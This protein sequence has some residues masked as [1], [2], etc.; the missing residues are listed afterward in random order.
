MNTMNI[1]KQKLYN[2]G[3]KKKGGFSLIESLVL[4]FI[5]SIFVLTAYQVF[6]LAAKYS[7]D[8]KSRTAAVEFATAEM[9]V[10]RNT[11]YEDI[12]LDP[13]TNPPNG[14]VVSGSSGTGL[15][16]SEIKTVNSI[17]YRVLTEIYYVDDPEDDSGGDDNTNDYKKVLVTILWGSG[18]ANT[19]DTS[20]SVSLTSFFVPPSGNE[21]AITDGAL[22]VNVVDSNGDAVSGASV[23][24][25]DINGAP[26]P[27]FS[28]SDTT[29]SSGN[30]LFEGVPVA[31]DMY[32]ITVTKA[33]SEEIQTEDPYPTSSYYP[34]YTHASILAGTIT[35]VTI[36][37]EEVPDLHV[38]TKDPFG[39]TVSDVD[40]T[41]TG[42][43]ILGLD[44]SNDPVHINTNLSATSDTSGEVDCDSDVT[45]YV[46]SVGRY[47]FTLNETGYVLWKMD[48][49]SDTELGST[50]VDSGTF[51]TDMIIIDESYDGILVSVTDSVTGG[52]FEG[53]SVQ[54]TNSS[55]GYD[56]TQQTDKYGKAYF[57]EDTIDELD[58]GETYDIAVTMTDY[59]D[60]NDSVTV[61]GFETFETEMTPSS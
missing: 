21:S 57:P 48:P 59:T 5:I 42:G 7:S 24:V 23:A 35:T 2:F 11:P 3:K 50:D 58:N 49:G 15:D 27:N 9:E 6:V 10:L 26:A 44:T 30:V 54:V 31:M 47:A 8:T 60:V 17:T 61:T 37:Q 34:Y 40:F 46:A 22:S 1:Q 14:S 25:A 12:E 28:D 52:P 32:E 19:S 16:Y 38:F 13:A 53:V 18:I 56:V 4:L 20:H 29:D 36:V 51:N 55:V 41:F 33:S 43:R 39:V 45:N